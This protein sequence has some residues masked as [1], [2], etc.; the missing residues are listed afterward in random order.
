MP[1]HI[2]NLLLGKVIYIAILIAVSIAVL[3]LVKIQSN[4]I[5]V[6]TSDKTLHTAAYFFLTLSWL[7]S[8]VLKKSFR[9]KAKK[10]ILDTGVQ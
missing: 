8:F 4:S 1:M 6:T 9:Q 2:K 5:G 7:Y 3:S 10:T